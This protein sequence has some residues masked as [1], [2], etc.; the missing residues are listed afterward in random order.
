MPIAGILSDNITVNIDGGAAVQWN[1]HPT[2]LHCS[3]VNGHVDKG[4]Y[5]SHLTRF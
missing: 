3:N 1:V 2:S 4:Y 5:S